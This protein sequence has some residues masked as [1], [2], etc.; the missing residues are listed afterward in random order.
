MA[1]LVDA[2]DL[3]SFD[4]KR[5]VRVQVPPSALLELFIGAISSVGLE[6]YIDIVEVRG[7]NPLSPTKELDLNYE[8]HTSG[9]KG[10]QFPKRTFGKPNITGCDVLIGSYRLRTI[11]PNVL[12]MIWGDHSPALCDFSDLYVKEVLCQK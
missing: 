5:V 4:P 9:S 3:K 11:Q 1:E 8:K 10:M 6:R 12:A 7:S 2:K